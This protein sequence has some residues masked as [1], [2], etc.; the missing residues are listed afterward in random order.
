MLR[1]AFVILVWALAT[2][3]G[4]PVQWIALRLNLPLRRLV[5]MYYHRL[6]LKLLGV[7][8]EVQGIPAP[9][10]PLLFV[11]NHCSWLDILVF[12]SV[13]PLVF[14]AKHEIERWPLV[15]LLAKLQ[16][17]VF[18]DRSRRHATES[19]NRE[20]AARMAAGDPVVL[21]GEGTASDGNFVLPFRSALFG[22]V[23]DAL[24]GAERGYVQPVSLAYT[25]LHGLPMGRQFRPFAAWYGDIGLMAHFWRVLR[26]GAIDAVVSFGPAIAVDAAADRKALARTTHDAVRRMNAAALAGKIGVSGTAVS[27]AGE[28]R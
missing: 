20:I 4:I 8:V 17:T 23:R 3:I 5:P 7:R 2:A 27:F 26:E 9:E 28:T 10:R 15:G 18:V 19:V 13:T 12:S 16:R 22:A 25:R 11:A 21:F 6:C 14:I 24:G 1:A